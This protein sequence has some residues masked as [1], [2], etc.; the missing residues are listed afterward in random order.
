MVAERPTTGDV[1]EL[2]RALPPPQFDPAAAIQIHPARRQ[3]VRI[4]SVGR[5]EKARPS[6][7][8][9]PPTS[10]SM[11]VGAHTAGLPL[12]A[13]I[14]GRG[15]EVR[16]HFG[17]WLD[18]QAN[19]DI[20]TLKSLLLGA[21]PAVEFEDTKP[22]V[23]LPLD[24][25]DTAGTV[26]GYPRLR[27]GADG[28]LPYDRLFRAMGDDSWDALIVSIPLDDATTTTIRNRITNEIRLF[29]RTSPSADRPDPV[30][31]Y[32]N[33]L[34]E[35]L[36]RN[37]SSGQS[38]GA[39]RTSVLLL[40]DRR[41]YPRLA[42]L[43][44][45]TFAPP[46]GGGE[47]LRIWDFPEALQL[48]GGW[49]IANAAPDAGRPGRYSAPFPFQTVLTSAQLAA[50]FHL[51]VFETPGFSV[52]AEPGLDFDTE[53]TAAGS[54]DRILT[55]GSVITGP[56]ATGRPYELQLDNLTR[57]AFVTGVTG[58][59]KTVTTT[60][61]V[62][63]LDAAAV[64]FL[65]IEPTKAEYRNLAGD[66]RSPADGRPALGKRLRV[67][68]LGDEQT[69][70]FRM[71]PFEPGAPERELGD[72]VPIAQH[73][74][75]LRS[76]FSAAFGMWTPLPQIL[77]RCLYEI[78]A[79]RGWDFATGDNRRR[80]GLLPPNAYP[81][82]TDLSAKVDDVVG[83]LGY[84][85]EISSNVRAALKTRVDGL[86]TGAKGRMLDVQGSFP[87]QVI[88]DAPTVLE[89]ESMGDDD[90]KAF[91]M[92]LLLIRLV[93]YRREQ[94]A[95]GEIQTGGL[96]HLLVIEEAH[97]LLTNAVASGDPEQAN[98]RAKAVEAFTN[99]LSEIR[100]Y[101][102]GV[103][104]VDQ[105]PVR[106]APDVVKNTDLKI[107]HRI[108]A[109]D[110]REVLGRTMAMDERQVRAI[111]TLGRGRAAIFHE[112]D[113]APLLV[114]IAP[115]PQT[116]PP[117]DIR[118][119]MAAL[120]ASQNLDSSLRRSAACA[121]ICVDLSICDEARRIIE[122]VD[123]R[124][125]LARLALT[126]IEA[127]TSLSSPIGAWSELRSILS[128]KM[129]PSTPIDQLLRSTVVHGSEW[130]A[131]RRGAQAAWTFA[132]AS[133]FEDALRSALL[134]AI[135]QP[136][137]PEA[138]AY[139]T[140]AL[141]LHRR[142]YAPFARC[143]RVCAQTDPPVCLYRWA[144][145]DAEPAIRSRFAEAD[146]GAE[147]PPW[148]ERVWAVVSSVADQM[149]GGEGGLAGGSSAEGPT[150]P[151]GRAAL[152]LTQVAIT[153]EIGDPRAGVTPADLTARMDA[154]LG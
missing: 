97:R 84:A 133:R 135:S 89:L 91:L 61:L 75:L 129:R 24:G 43:W 80:S 138:A 82:L 21:Y 40:G 9:P 102:Q 77:E 15:G 90:D 78:Y 104:I 1:D 38:I 35:G 115:P 85:D 141:A 76:V 152:C 96:Q 145:T 74:D 42:G 11:V 99:L 29:E 120:R 122:D 153:S 126:L 54:G 14:A 63:G 16:V 130:V 101:G 112:G 50:Y 151:R 13:A 132:D 86:R 148:S 117:G 26:L 113:D 18:D 128:A 81:T 72:R 58:S 52:K 114:S 95:R 134:A 31:R 19:E 70:P 143:E 2:Q 34:L 110:D 98:P 41:S 46:R 73:I 7:R 32:Y 88:L 55:L 47:P 3:M 131:A 116:G 8:T 109:G 118:A 4:R 25:L 62:R 23:A 108:V 28:A 92:G 67:F 22:E 36:L 136:D 147:P 33:E 119:Q 154:L 57:H 139:A 100:A 17:T 12:V 60:N 64:P 56:A 68:T 106:L 5:A 105:V 123:I 140:V 94:A 146:G 6:E 66:D 125:T 39:W 149:V 137:P 48:A 127:P 107:A 144:A 111:S 59:G 142:T 20:A 93:E 45:G 37:T 51:P 150:T 65:V 53:P 71:N 121:A 124:T 30:T 83:R 87:M 10:E 79:D 49:G 27:P 69:S 103:L 44:R